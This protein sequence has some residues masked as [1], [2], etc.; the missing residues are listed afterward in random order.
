G[1]M[2]DVSGFSMS[3][4]AIARTETMTVLDDQ[5]DQII[6]GYE[7]Y[8]EELE[9]D[10]E[11]NYQP[12]DMSAE[13]SDFESML[14][15]F[16][17]NYELE[18]GGRKLA[19]KDKEIERLKEAADEVSKGKLSQRRNRERQEKKKLEKVTNTLSSLKF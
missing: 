11:Q 17:D 1:A 13:R 14:D 5:Y 18:S 10:E 6:N 7:N 19:K 15:D 3:S 12:F 2:S 8:E 16:L 9:E 4:S